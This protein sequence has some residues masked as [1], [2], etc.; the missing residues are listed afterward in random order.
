M[1]CFFAAFMLLLLVAPLS[2]DDRLDMRVLYCGDPGSAREADFRSFLEKH[3][4][5]V[6]V[7]DL[8]KF[9]E[10]QAKAEDVVIFDWSYLNWGKDGT[11]DKRTQQKYEAIASLPQDFSRPAILIG[12]TGG[13]VGKQ[14]QL[15]IDWLCLCLSDK[16]HKMVLDHPVFHKPLEVDPRLEEIATPDGY[17]EIGAYTLDDSLGP[18]MKVWRVQTKDFPE[19]DP[20]LVSILYGFTDSPE[21][22]VI[23]QGI[24]MKGPDTVALGRQANF[25]LWGFSAPPADMTP[26]AQRLFVNVVA[27]MCQFDGQVPLVRSKALSR[28]W[29]L[30]YATIPR[31]LSDG[32]QRRLQDKEYRSELEKMVA[33]NPAVIPKEFKGG[34][35]AYIDS[36]VERMHAGLSRFMEK[37]L[38]ENLRKEFGLDADKYVA[39][40]KQN[41]EF[42]RPDREESMKFGMFVVDEDA[43]AIKSSNRRIETLD[44]CISM[45]EKNDRP[46]LALRLLKRYTEE[47]FDTP[48][49]WRAWLDK[50]RSRLFFSD[51]GGYKFFVD[52]RP[53]PAGKSP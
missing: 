50:N 11:D 18:K 9:K 33:K 15:K 13:S 14:L 19:I 20:G 38:P 1:R 40:Y 7:G 5:K 49:Q 44:R 47:S 42:I 2:A 8:S 17:S 25:F 53:Q 52:T 41:M 21:T 35:N 45:L 32:P 46:E 31:E 16:A 39:Y 28:E 26:A 29:A 27:Y 3:F 24:S 36:Q 10:D 4:T 23:G 37:S 12:E 48:A 30:R 6:T 43:K 34:A 51:V 22:E